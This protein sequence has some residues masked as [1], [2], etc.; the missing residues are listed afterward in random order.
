MGDSG[1][2]RISVGV[3]GVEAGTADSDSGKDEPRMPAFRAVS[4]LDSGFLTTGME[5]SQRVKARIKS[6]A[7]T[8]MKPKINLQLT[9]KP[10]RDPSGTPTRFADV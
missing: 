8:A 7:K 2:D 1:H 6:N 4:S 10:M 5:G 9:A 3:V